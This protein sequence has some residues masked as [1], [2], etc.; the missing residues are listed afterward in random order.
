MTT[1][2]SP[3]RRPRRGIAKLTSRSL[4]LLSRPEIGNQVARHPEDRRL[5]R[6]TLRHAEHRQIARNLG[7]SAHAQTTESA[8]S[9]V[10]PGAP[11]R[12]ERGWSALFLPPRACY[13]PASFTLASS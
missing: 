5:P 4:W 3:G 12:V 13:A 2:R 7:P 6:V 11:T 10:M 1:R 8:K 9:V